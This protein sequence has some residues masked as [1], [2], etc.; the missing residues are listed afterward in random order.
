MKIDIFFLFLPNY[1]SSTLRPMPIL[2]QNN[3]SL[4]RRQ[5]N[6][7]HAERYG[8]PEH[9]LHPERRVDKVFEQQGHGDDRGAEKE[10]Q[11]DGCAVA[12]IV[13]AEPGVA[14]ITFIDGAD[15]PRLE[16]AS[17]PAYGAAGF[18]AKGNV[19]KQSHC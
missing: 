15:R 1:F 3:I 8:G 17:L 18:Q 11:E 5:D 7:D 16:K 13:L 2:Q 14:H 12:D 4:H 19:V 10:N 6:G 9:A